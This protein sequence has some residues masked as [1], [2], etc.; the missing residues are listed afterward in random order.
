[1]A[2]D[3]PGHTVIG[4]LGSGGF[5]TVYRTR[6]LAVGRETAVKVDGRVLQTERDRRRFFRE[7]TAAGRLSGHPH[8]IDLYDAGTLSDGRPY[9]V[10][11]L[12][13]AGSLKDDLRVN[14]PMNPDL[15]CRIGADLADALAAAHAAGVLHRDIKPGNILINP[16]GLVGL[17]D[18]GL[19]SIIAASG[20]QSVT[21]EA[22]TPAYA[23]P[24]SFQAAEPTIAADIYS[25]AATLYALMAGRPPRYSDTSPVSAAAILALHSQPIEDIPGVPPRILALLR[26]CLAADPARRLPSAATFRDALAGMSEPREP[27]RFVRLS[28]GGHLSTSGPSASYDQSSGE[29]SVSSSAAVRDIWTVPDAWD[30]TGTHAPPDQGTWARPTGQGLA[31]TVRTGRRRTV[32]LAAAIGGSLIA[33]AVAAGIISAN[34]LGSST[35]GNTDSGGSGPPGAVGTFGIATTTSHCPAAAVAGAGARCPVAPECWQGIVEIEST[36]TAEMSPCVTAHSWQTFAIGIMPAGSS[37][38]DVDI[39]QANPTVR[40]VCSK[41]VLLRSRTGRGRQFPSGRWQIQV[42]PP[43]EAAYD[44]GIRTY[45]CLASEGFNESRTSLFRP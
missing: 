25:L 42:L 19:A 44:S 33:V 27:A 13:P 37:T 22:L 21:R 29:A 2:P 14:G 1:M 20:E 43:D 32:A 16:Y 28:A 5:A 4:V 31:R 26:Q 41:A 7:V 11:E 18:F 24:E 17:S 8:V 45:R 23:P 3:I 10:M 35:P 9:L 12:C 40:A 38:Y 6:Q 34:L 39:V 30:S 36:I 15:A